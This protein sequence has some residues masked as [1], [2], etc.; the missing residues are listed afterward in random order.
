MPNV[1]TN[2]ENKV[3]TITINR[4]D[5]LNALNQATLHELNDIIEQAKEDQQTA[6]IIC[7]RC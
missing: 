6:A 2:L 5:K 3:L 1:L 4:P 7:R